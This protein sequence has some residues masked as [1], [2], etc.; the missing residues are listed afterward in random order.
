MQTE[1]KPWMIVS[2]VAV[3]A[4]VLLFWGFKSTQPGGY[5]PSPGAGGRPFD[6]PSYPGGGSAPPQSGGGAYPS[7]GG[8]PS[9][10]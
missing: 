6:V 9:R 10:G 8:Y 5:V 7:G 2:A 1:L 4:A 3:L